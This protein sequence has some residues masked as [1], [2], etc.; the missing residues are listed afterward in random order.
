MAR[1]I[2]LLLMCVYLICACFQTA[3]A[4]T[5]FIEHN[6][7]LNFRSGDKVSGCATEVVREAAKRAGV[8]AQFVLASWDEGYAKAKDDAGSCIY[9]KGQAGRA[10][11][12]V[13]VGGPDRPGALLGVCAR[14]LS[15]KLAKVDDLKTFRVGAV[16]DARAA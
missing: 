3:M 16:D 7:P 13:P 9:S 2:S 4:A 5:F 6:P 10:L 14:G 15:Q 1:P 12:A 11:Q 8:P